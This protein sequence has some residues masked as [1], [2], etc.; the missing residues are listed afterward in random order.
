[1]QES[2]VIIHVAFAVVALVAGPLAVRFPNGSPRHRK[3]GRFYLGAWIAFGSTGFYLGTLHR[4]ITPFEVLNVLGAGFVLAALYALWRRKQIGRRWK[5]LHYRSMLISYAFVA[6]ATVNQVLMRAGL[7][8][9]LWVFGALVLVP[10][11][12]LPSVVRRLDKTYGFAVSSRG[13]ASGAV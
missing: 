8:Y 10:F 6:V 11:L 13:R 2:A 5:R 3:I 12:V 1:M 7:E 9:P 4:G